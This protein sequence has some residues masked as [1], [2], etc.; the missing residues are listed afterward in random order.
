MK[1]LRNMLQRLVE[2]VERANVIQHSRTGHSIPAEDWSELFMLTHEARTLLATMPDQIEIGCYVEGGI[3]D[4]VYCNVPAKVWTMDM[5]EKADDEK[6]ITHMDDA[7]INEFAFLQV[8]V[9]CDIDY[10]D[11]G[12][13]TI[14]R[15]TVGIYIYEL[16]SMDFYTMSENPMAPDGVNQYAGSTKEGLQKPPYSEFIFDCPDVIKPAVIQRLK[17]YLEKE[18]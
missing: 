11:N 16:G 8:K 4:R 14:D 13:R 7:E 18:K 2:K 1:E 10:W 12:G 17:N 6:C 15:Y 9:G 5:D 3:L